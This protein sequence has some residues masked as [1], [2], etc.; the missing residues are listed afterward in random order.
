MS[1]NSH[2][3]S[4]YVGCQMDF[5]Y[6]EVKNFPTS[7]HT[8]K[9]NHP[10]TLCSTVYTN[11]PAHPCTHGKTVPRSMYRTRHTVLALIPAYSAKPKTHDHVLKA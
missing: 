10:G 6:L 1:A 5:S 9:P 2:E 3:T 8:H 11:R 7:H 4:Y